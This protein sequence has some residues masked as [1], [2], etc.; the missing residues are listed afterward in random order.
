M[1]DSIT[2][3]VPCFVQ[4]TFV[5]SREVPPEKGIYSRTFG[6][7]G[8]PRLWQILDM[9]SVGT[10]EKSLMNQNVAN[11]VLK[12]MC[13]KTLESWPIATADIYYPHG[14][15]V[16]VWYNH[17]TEQIHTE[18][19]ETAK[20]IL[21]ES[22]ISESQE[23]FDSII[24]GSEN[25]FDKINGANIMVWKKGDDTSAADADVLRIVNMFK[26][27]Q[28]VSKE[29]WV[30]GDIP[31][32]AKAKELSQDFLDLE[33]KYV[34][35]T[36]D[37]EDGRKNLSIPLAGI[38]IDR[39]SP[40]VLE[41]VK[42][43]ED[44]IIFQYCPGY[45]YSASASTLHVLDPR[46]KGVAQT[47]NIINSKILKELGMVDWCVVKVNKNTGEITLSNEL[48]KYFPH[49]NP[50]QTFEPNIE[51]P[52]LILDQAKNY[53]ENG[54]PDSLKKLRLIDRKYPKNLEDLKYFGYRNEIVIATAALMKRVLGK[55][56]H[57]ILGEYKEKVM[58][59]SG[60]EYTFNQL[61]TSMVAQAVTGISETQFIQTGYP[62]SWN[63][64]ILEKNG[65]EF[66]SFG[67]TG[68]TADE[69]TGFG[70]TT[71]PYVL[72]GKT[73][74]RFKISK[75]VED[76][77]AQKGFQI[78]F[79]GGHTSQDGPMVSARRIKHRD[80]D[81]Y[82]TVKLTD[83]NVQNGESLND[84]HLMFPEKTRVNHLISDVSLVTHQTGK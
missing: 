20:N 51:W 79:G 19:Q 81:G 48:G 10:D 34:V 73:H 14:E 30:E 35:P 41:N 2:R 6:I 63:E 33:V 28:Q 54:N 21:V 84:I 44:E 46:W 7:I 31:Y 82:V 71:N 66:V 8:N 70:C 17:D 24:K 38:N 52:R 60:L 39:T 76:G 59:I 62:F 75:V 80:Q 55:L 53:I 11:R 64:K 23:V 29:N 50:S 45:S 58:N 22:E 65:K 13:Y 67:A 32:L 40:F 78:I 5:A 12:R 61:L 15:N 1:I 77:L 56:N 47:Q 57:K 26:A 49:R 3:P 42:G 69:Y 37:N 27:F 43:E 83:K 68:T 18:G 72:K 74:I 4:K 16:L 9:S 36:E 25:Y